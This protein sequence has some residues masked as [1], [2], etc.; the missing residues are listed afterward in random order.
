[1]NYFQSKYSRISGNDYAEKERQARKIYD[2]I[3]RRSKRQA[4]VRSAYF[5]KEKVFLKL[6]WNHLSQK[7]LGDRA[8]RIV[9]YKCAIDLIRSSIVKPVVTNLESSKEVYY[10]FY[11]KTKGREAF[12]VQIKQNKSGG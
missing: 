10:R 9:Y 4:Y 11:G 8:R 6:F 3:A 7:R 1:M 5:N 12:V 2:E